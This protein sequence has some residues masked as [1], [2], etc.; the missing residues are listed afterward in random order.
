LSRKYSHTTDPC[1][2]PV[3]T[4]AFDPAQALASVVLL[5]G[6]ARGF[7]EHRRIAAATG[8]AGSRF[9]SEPARV[10]AHA[11]DI[12]RGAV[13]WGARLNQLVG[14]ATRRTASGTLDDLSELPALFVDV[15]DEVALATLPRR[16][17]GFPRTALVVNSGRGRH[18]YWKLAQPIDV[19]TQEGVALAGYLLRNLTSEVGGDP[20]C[21][22]ASRCLRLPGSINYP[23][24]K[25]R[26]A[27]RVPVRA[28]IIDLRPERVIDV[29]WFTKR[30]GEPTA[31]EV[32]ARGAARA[33]VD[34]APVLSPRVDRL[35][36]NNVSTR[37]KFERVGAWP[38][39]SENDF[40]IACALARF[41]IDDPREIAAAIWVSRNRAA[42][43]QKHAGYYTR[44][45]A[46][47][48]ARVREAATC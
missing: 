38:S 3:D 13:S 1:A 17:R 45:A 28:E 36:R 33:P 18:L 30:Y 32:A 37:L 39:A 34:F 2:Q 48:I 10:V 6:G 26:A 7:I 27:G 47:A 24:E 8:E 21:T 16:L 20:A 46:Q 29:T 41:G 5:H 42:V 44:S 15:D 4:L 9:C 22:D 11:V 19:S 31:V 40:A 35:L 43:D 25:K 23:D 12:A 14:V